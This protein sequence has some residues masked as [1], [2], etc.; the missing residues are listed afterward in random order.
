MTQAPEPRLEVRLVVLPRHA[1]HAG[2]R[3]AP[4]RLESRPERI[5]IDVMEKRGE[6][7]L[8]S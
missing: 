4:E 8:L 5:D 1:I 7:F 2:S 6:L 3:F